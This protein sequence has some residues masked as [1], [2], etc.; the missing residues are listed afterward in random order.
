ML[1][2][3]YVTYIIIKSVI[4]R[5]ILGLYKYM[6]ILHPLGVNGNSVHCA[7]EINVDRIYTS[8]LIH[9]VCYVGFSKART[10]TIYRK[11]ERN[12]LVILVYMPT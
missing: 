12:L 5:V 9:F 1:Q 7:C 4:I 2:A 6:L 10:R 8:S 3:D 11:G